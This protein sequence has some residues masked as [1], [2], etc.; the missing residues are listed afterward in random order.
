MV[1]VLTKKT[2]K[3]NLPCPLSSPEPSHQFNISKIISNILYAEGNAGVISPGDEPDSREILITIMEYSGT[4]GQE[5]RIAALEKKCRE[6]DSQVMGLLNELLDLKAV[7]LKMSRQAGEYRGR[8]IPQE[9]DVQDTAYPEQADSV[10]SP[11]GATAS[12]GSTVIRLKGASQPVVPAAPPEPEMVRIMQSD[13][14]F[15]MEPR[16]GD[17]ST[18]DSSGG[19]GRNRKS[20]SLKNK[21]NP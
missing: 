15:K 13:G 9:P 1:R 5:D 17:S 3:T 11:S 7:S 12:D 4:A 20:I 16:R 2:K 21:K 19:W 6:M 10:P 8:E 14:T 18:M